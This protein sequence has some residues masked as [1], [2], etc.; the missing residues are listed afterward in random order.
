M[1]HRL[2]NKTNLKASEIRDAL[3]EGGGLVDNNAS[4]FFKG[5]AKVNIWSKYKPV[6]VLYGPQFVQDFD[7]NDK[8]Y[9][10]YEWWK[11][12]NGNCGINTANTVSNSITTFL[13][14]I[15]SGNYL[16]TYEIPN[17][18]YRLGDFRNY[19]IDACCPISGEF[20]DNYWVDD[21]GKLLFTLDC[22]N[23]LPSTNLTFD[24]ILVSTPVNGNVKMS[25][26]YMGILLWKEDGSNMFYPTSTSK[27]GTESV[28]F[29]VEGFNAPA[30]YGE[31]NI[32]PYASSAI[33][34]GIDGYEQSA[35]YVTLNTAPKKIYVHAPGT[36]V[37]TMPLA[38]YTI[39]EYGDIQIIYSINIKN[40]N[41]SA[42]GPLTI[43]LWVVKE[44]NDS[45][46]PAEG[47]TISNH[48]TFKIDTIAANS[49]TT[50]FSQNYEGAEEGKKEGPVLTVDKNQFDPNKC[51]IASRAEGFAV[52][53]MPLDE[54]NDKPID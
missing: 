43:E 42:M 51:W 36:L 7:P 17:K 35:T 31:W 8:E 29:E 53:Y 44:S 27:I 12:V 41:S 6:T 26:F 49:D 25:E 37:Y 40:S 32:I 46:N 24:D 30:F 38:G 19:D 5:N 39:D 47:N 16:W 50:Y 11:S 21:A 14:K 52:T 1:S 20:S 10:L 3:S 28:S 15:K 33:Q 18:P 4:S 13:N 48:V 9:Y 34:N 45:S 2:L 54:M 22:N 23:N